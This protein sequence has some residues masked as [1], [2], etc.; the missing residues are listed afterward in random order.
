MDEELVDVIECDEG[1]DE[2]ELGAEDC[3]DD[4]F[5]TPNL[6]NTPSNYPLIEIYE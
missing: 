4:A 3:S 5:D 1:V 6:V 2:E